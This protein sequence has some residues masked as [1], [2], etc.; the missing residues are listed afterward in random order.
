MG[1]LFKSKQQKNQKLFEQAIRE[2]GGVKSGRRT[3]ICPGCQRRVAVTFL[4]PGDSYK[5]TN[6]GYRTYAKDVW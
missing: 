3:F 2:A 6:C 5:C 4:G 1:L